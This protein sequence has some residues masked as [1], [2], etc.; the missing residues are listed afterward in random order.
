M[1]FRHAHAVLMYWQK[2]RHPVVLQTFTVSKFC[3][4]LGEKDLFPKRFGV[5]PEA[6]Y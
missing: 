2:K 3:E 1:A 5:E 6:I 4:T